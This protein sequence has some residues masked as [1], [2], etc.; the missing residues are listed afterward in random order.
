MTA[1]TDTTRARF[2]AARGAAVVAGLFCLVVGTLLAVVHFQNPD[3]SLDKNEE[4]ARLRA[5]LVKVSD[6]DVREAIQADLRQRDLELRRGFFG[7][8]AFMRA[9][10]GLLVGGF[11]VFVIGAALAASYG[12]RLPHPGPEAKRTPVARAARWAVAGVAT[13]LV[14]A[15]IG[16][17]VFSDTPTPPPAGVPENGSGDAGGET[18]A[19]TDAVDA[20][21]PPSADEIAR[22]WPRFRGPGGLGISHDANVPQTWDGKTGLNILWRTP[23]PLRGANS[24]VVWGKRVFCTGAAEKVREVFCFDADTGRLAWRTPV[25]TPAGAAAKPPEILED[26]GFSASTAATD[27]RFV[28]AI[29][30]NGDIA[31]L[32]V[33]GK[34]VWA[35]NLGPFRNSYGYA[36]SLHIYG[37]TVIIII[38]QGTPGKTDSHLVALNLRTGDP[39]WKTQRP[40]P[41]SW[42][43]PILYSTGEREEFATV[44]NPFVIAYN[45]ADGKELW[46]AKVLDGDVAPSP[47][48]ANGMVYAANTGAFFAAVRAGGSGD[49]TATHVA[50]KGEDGLPDIVS[51]IVTQQV[52]LLITTDGLFTAYAA[53]E[54]KFLWE[55]EIDRIFMASPTLVGDVIYLP[56]IKGL[57]HRLA[58]TVAG[59]KELSAS[60]LGEEVVASPA[61]LDGRIIVRGKKHLWAIQDGAKTEIPPAPEGEEKEEH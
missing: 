12:K 47:V 28:C 22:Q 45:P 17:L 60:P 32:T 18:A 8:Q 29:F 40:V 48:Y 39:A 19:P 59:M 49:V 44:A 33:D 36:S 54:G 7:R 16:L 53:A 13:V 30:A 41:A 37:D 21:P 1:D 46:R 26:T 3:M 4:L 42:G 14:T 5:A 34:T 50:W 31:C 10:G 2:L 6:D 15:A 52:A 38:D 25:S 27:G 9:G 51:P 57:T 43:S 61:F 23:L 55:A 11:V 20:G 56:D 58:V 35:K 24:P